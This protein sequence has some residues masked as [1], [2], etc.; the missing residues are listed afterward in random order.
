MQRCSVLET[1]QKMSMDEWT[2]YILNGCHVGDVVE[3]QT[4]KQK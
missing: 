4:K 2:L 3:A 1:V